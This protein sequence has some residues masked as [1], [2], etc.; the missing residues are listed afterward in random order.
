[1]LAGA[2]TVEE[3]RKRIEDW[4]NDSMDRV[5]GWYKRTSHAWLWI[6]GTA[7]CLLVNADSISLANV[8]WNDQA[9]RAATVA[10]A[11]KYVQTP[12]APRKSEANSTSTENGGGAGQSTAKPK[13]AT[14]TPPSSTAPATTANTQGSG[15]DRTTSTSL[16]AGGQSSNDQLFNRLN[17][18]RDNLNKA[19]IPL[20]W[21]HVSQG[22]HNATAKCW[23]DFKAA[24]PSAKDT[25][26][27]SAGG[28]ASDANTAKSANPPDNRVQNK[29][30]DADPR[31]RMPLA[32]NYW[33]W[34]LMK[35]FGIALTALAISQGAPFWFDLLQKAV[36]LRLAGDAPDEKKK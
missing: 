1:L 35:L 28:V 6:I 10:A 5:S 4:F 34:W 16:G 22:V 3:Q 27:S 21:C 33:D 31:I 8:F 19:Q 30:A 12:S 13:P 24:R 2:N 17:E 11:T 18:L 25:N 20:G 23:P 29:L 14:Q 26:S 36:N 9:L 15:T 32:L 7:L